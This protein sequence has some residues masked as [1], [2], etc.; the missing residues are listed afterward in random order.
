[1]PEQKT[2]TLPPNLYLGLLSF[3]IDLGFG[4]MVVPRRVEFWCKCSLIAAANMESY[5]V[6]VQE[7]IS[8]MLEAIAGSYIKPV[9]NSFRRDFTMRAN[10]R[11]KSL[12]IR[13]SPTE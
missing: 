2:L 3:Q 5:W 10:I 6:F 1:L 4:I 7:Q 13:L 11:E 12:E 9:L 8:A